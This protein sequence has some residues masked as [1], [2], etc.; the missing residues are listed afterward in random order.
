MLSIPACETGMH[1]F[2]CLQ[3]CGQCQTGTTC[4]VETGVCPFGCAPG[5]LGSQCR[6]GRV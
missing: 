5:Y 1:G 2:G 6:E 4:D 3:K